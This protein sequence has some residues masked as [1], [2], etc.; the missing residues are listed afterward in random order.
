MWSF[1]WLV[2]GVPLALLVGLLLLPLVLSL[3]KR[4]TLG[5]LAAGALFLSGAVGMELLSGYVLAYQE[6]VVNSRYVLVTL[7]EETLEMLAIGLAVASLLS[8]FERDVDTGTWRVVRLAP[9]VG[10]SRRVQAPSADG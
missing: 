8:L 9:R 6:W 5:I 2:I 1:P 4:T 7:I 10:R 3:P